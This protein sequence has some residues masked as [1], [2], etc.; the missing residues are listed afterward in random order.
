MS[1]LLI[2]ESP[3]Q[4]LPTLAVAIGLNEA[5]FLQQLHWRL[6]TSNHEKDG[7]RW[8]YDTAEEWSKRFPFWSTPTIRR[9]INGL[10]DRKLIITTDQ[11]NKMKIDN[12]LWYAIDYD[13]I[14]ALPMITPCDQID[15]TTRSKRSHALDQIDQANNLENTLRIS[16]KESEGQQPAPALLNS[17]QQLPPATATAQQPATP[18]VTVKAAQA[19]TPSSAAPLPQW[20]PMTDMPP[21]QR[22]IVAEKL[23]GSADL[24]PRRNRP[25]F[26]SPHVTAA[27]NA[28]GYVAAG[29]GSN[30][31]EI[32]YERFSAYQPDERLSAPQE[33]DL[34][35]LAGNAGVRPAIEAYG[36]TGYKPRNVALIIEWTLDPSKY[37]QRGTS[38]GNTSVSGKQKQDVQ[39]EPSAPVAP[40][41]SIFREPEPG[42][43]N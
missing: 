20:Q 8:V 35:T 34:M 9:I 26:K 27:L 36:R 32:Y 29:Q 4:V 28:A 24:S 30:P 38:N 31:V 22:D 41:G 5:I 37:K 42:E 10:R 3:L 7:R 33:Y 14:D 1:K 40:T 13:Q 25:T 21:T 23:N 15:Q 18:T 12:T 11:Y 2:N 6:G 39:I 43:Y 17:Q 19:P 16:T